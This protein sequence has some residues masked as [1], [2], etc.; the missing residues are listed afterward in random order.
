MNREGYKSIADPKAGEI[1]AYLIIHYIYLEHCVLKHRKRP[2]S[3]QASRNLRS[4]N[5]N[6]TYHSLY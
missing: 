1:A 6:T 4:N 2:E 5:I 3:N